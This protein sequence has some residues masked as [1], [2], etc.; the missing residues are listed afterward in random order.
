MEGYTMHS[1]RKLLNTAVVSVTFAVGIFPASAL[2]FG[3]IAPLPSLA[4]EIGTSCADCPD[5]RGA[6]SI[7]NTTGVTVSYQY[8]WGSK[9]Q[10]K[11]MTLR[12]GM[13]ETHWYPLGEDPHH[14]VPVPY[15][16]FDRVGG[17]SQVTT[18]E[19]KLNFHAVG[20]AGYG[21][22]QN[23]AEPKR[24]VFRYASNGR[25]LDLKAK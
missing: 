24:Y 25:D 21:P 5:Y 3:A 23:R 11:N 12:S 1:V 17:D 16:R 6:Y 22:K 8:R 9:H 4:G 7:E 10:W 2:I 14:Q 15:I 18:Q 19:Y 20:Y 13:I